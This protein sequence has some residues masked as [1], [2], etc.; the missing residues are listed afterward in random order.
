MK[1]QKENGAWNKGIQLDRIK[2]PNMGHLQ[3]HSPESIENMRN[4]H[5]GQIAWN[6]GVKGLQPWMNLSG[7]NLGVKGRVSGM[8]GKKHSEETKLKMRIDRSGENGANWQGG[9]TKLSV[10][11]RNSFKTRQWRSD[12]FTRDNFTCQEC[13]QK[14]GRLHADH[15]EPF[16]VI[17]ARN[18][19]ET[20]DQAIGCEEF[21]NLNNG[22]TLCVDCHKK[23]DTYLTGALKYK[24]A[25]LSP[26]QINA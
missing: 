19:I 21:W 8:K 6:K 25:V 10:K 22:R 15:I 13:E 3:K 23:T 2:Y 5:K 26:L 14:G 7:L 20:F 9:I 12:V 11:I 18:H 1:W 16:S 17:F 4:S 24:K